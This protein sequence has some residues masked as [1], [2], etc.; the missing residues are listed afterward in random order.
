MLNKTKYIFQ[1][2]ISP[3]DPEFQ[4]HCNA[5]PN[6]V[7]WVISHLN[8]APFEKKMNSLMKFDFALK[9]VNR[10]SFVKITPFERRSEQVAFFLS[11]NTNHLFRATRDEPKRN[12]LNSKLNTHLKNVYS[13]HSALEI[14]EEG[15]IIPAQP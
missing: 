12:D 9:P 15:R 13:T 14:R 7:Y 11:L 2:I 4:N 1:T 8:I 5:L 6:R 3:S 10:T